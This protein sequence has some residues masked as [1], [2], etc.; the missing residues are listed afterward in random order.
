MKTENLLKTRK[1]TIGKLARMLLAVAAWHALPASA[2]IDRVDGLNVNVL[3]NTTY[4]LDVD[5]NG[6]IDFNLSNV[7]SFAGTDYYG[8]SFYNRSVTISGAGANDFVGGQAVPGYL[9]GSSTSMTNS[10]VLD[11]TQAYFAQQ[12]V[13]SYQQPYSY[14]C[15][16]FG[17]S[18]CTDWNTVYVYGS[19]GGY[20]ISD[21]NLGNNMLFVFKFADTHGQTD[22]GWLNLSI[23]DS[24][25]SNPY[26]F[27]LN[28]YGWD[29]T[30]AAVAA[31]AAAA[32]PEPSNLMFMSAGVLGILLYRRKASKT[33]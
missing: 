10:E 11:Q 14:S 31:G 3:A 19:V 21:T 25:T 26:Q 1:Y 29:D 18:T 24:G 28:G 22:Y 6:T 23:A 2:N 12:V 9:I 7:M 15:G 13:S 27:T 20:T 30:G 16:L 4:H 32:V 17:L 5:H 8:W 33:C